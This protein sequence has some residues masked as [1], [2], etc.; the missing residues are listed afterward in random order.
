MILNEIDS[1]VALLIVRYVGDAFI[2]VRIGNP[3]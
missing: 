2:T 3:G 1:F